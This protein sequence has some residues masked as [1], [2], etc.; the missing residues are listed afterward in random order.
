[1]IKDNINNTI[2]ISTKD[3]KTKMERKTIHDTKRKQIREQGVNQ[4]NLAKSDVLLKEQ[5]EADNDK[6]RNRKGNKVNGIFQLEA[7]PFYLRI[8]QNSLQL[9]IQNSVQAFSSISLTNIG[10]GVEH[11]EATQSIPYLRK[12]Y[13]PCLS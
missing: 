6:K 8:L 2:D 3:N 13:P 5:E 12:S 11:N 1:M 7:I 10:D 4:Q 9:I